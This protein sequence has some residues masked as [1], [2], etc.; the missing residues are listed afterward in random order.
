M[1]LSLEKLV[2][3]SFGKSHN[4]AVPNLAIFYSPDYRKN[5]YSPVGKNCVSLDTGT[6]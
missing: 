5:S 3:P 1:D 4:F 2:K 6:Y